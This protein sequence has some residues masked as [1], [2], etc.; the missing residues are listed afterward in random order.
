MNDSNELAIKVSNLNKCYNI[1]EKPIDMFWELLT[2]TER[3]KEYWA[4][5]DISFEIKRG[6][7]VGIIGRNGAG[8]STL[9]K[10][11]TGTLDRT[12]GEIKTNGKI[13]A[14]L[15]LGSGFNQEYT[16]RENI[17]MGGMCRGMTKKEIDSKLDYIIDFSELGDVIDNQFRTYSTG[18]QARLTFATAI[19]VSPEILIIDE[20]LAVGD[21]KFQLKC[22]NRMREFAQSGATVLFVTHSMQSIYNLCTRGLLLHQG[23]LYKDDIPRRIGYAYEEILA[24]D[25]SEKEIQKKATFGETSDRLGEAQVLSVGMMDQEG[26]KVKTIYYGSDYIVNV[27]CRFNEDIENINVGFRVQTSA[28][29]S[30]YATNT[31]YNEHFITGKK[32][33]LIDVRFTF[34]CKLGSNDYLLGAGMSQVDSDK[35]HRLLHWIVEGYDFT[36]IAHN[37]F[38]GNFDLGGKLIDVSF[39]RGD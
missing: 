5:K 36:V 21:A 19:S 34:P 22:M 15:E 31:T 26:N 30:I 14:I 20:A 10:L 29:Q 16:G 24:S 37:T 18:M 7:V 28:G 2:K 9:L 39:S 38:Q 6:E 27:K 13:S 25:G 23:V 11:L 1:Y 8:K 35:N 33:D 32:G 17:Y 4:L 3:H 12:S